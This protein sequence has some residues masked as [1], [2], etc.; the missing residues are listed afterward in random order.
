M[1]ASIKSL[2]NCYPINSGPEDG[3]PST[4]IGL[5]SSWNC[6]LFQMERPYSCLSMVQSI[7]RQQAEGSQLA[8]KFPR[9]FITS[10]DNLFPLLYLCL[11]YQELKDTINLISL[12]AHL[13][14]LFVSADPQPQILPLPIH[15]CILNIDLLFLQANDNNAEVFLYRRKKAKKRRVS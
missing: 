14:Y 11:K 4:L 7:S 9:L 13:Y 5:E 1:K 12:S 2:M 8:S 10:N 6:A 3:S 15:V